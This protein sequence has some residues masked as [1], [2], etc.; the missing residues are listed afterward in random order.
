[1]AVPP[2]FLTV[3]V[4]D[5]ADGLK[6]ADAKQPQAVDQ[7]SEKIFQPGIGPHTEAQTVRLVL[8]EMRAARPARYSRVKFAVPYPTERRRKCDLAVHAGGGEP[9]CIEVKMWRLMEDNGKPNDN[10]L[11]HVLSP[12]AQHRSALTDCER[13][14]SSG[15]TGRKAILIYG[16]EA[17]GW[18]LR[19]VI[20][21]FQALAR[22]RT[23]LSECQVAGFDGLC[24]PI[25]RSGAV[26]GWELLGITP[27][28][29]VDR[30]Q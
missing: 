1:V 2:S 8:N 6:A 29:D 27:H 7:R 15:F 3:F 14:S 26:Y 30:S 28:L 11:V 10:I 24:H 5:F 21:A 23:H 19:L 25:H 17:E 18:P 9:W 4:A 13:L 22:T 20:D 12:Y 16:Y